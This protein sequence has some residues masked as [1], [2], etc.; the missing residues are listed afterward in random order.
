M[1]SGCD[2]FIQLGVERESGF[3]LQET[4]NKLFEYFDF[5]QKFFFRLLTKFQITRPKKYPQSSLNLLI[6]TCKH[7]ITGI[8]IGSIKYHFHG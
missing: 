6:K 7:N 1:R 5:I 3:G 4:K 2:L 8:L